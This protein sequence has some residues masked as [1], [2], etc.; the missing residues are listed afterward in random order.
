[1]LSR[2][3]KITLFIYLFLFSIIIFTSSSTPDV[4]VEKPDY[5]PLSVVLK[6]MDLTFEYQPAAGILKI[7]RNGEKV[8]L[9]LETNEI[10]FGDKIEFLDKK[11]RFEQG[12]V[13]V[14]SEGI[15]IMIRHLMKRRLRWTYKEGIFQIQ[16]W[17]KEKKERSSIESRERLAT[18]KR[19]DFNI[20][21]IVIDAGHGGK[22]PGGIGYQG[23]KEKDLVLKV[24]EEVT[25]ELKKKFRDKEIIMIRDSD[26]F[27][28]LEERAELANNTSPGQN[29]IF[30]S[31]HANVGLDK[32][33]MGYES[34]YLSF[35]PFGEE[36]R[37]VASKENSVLEF[38]VPE[39][40]EYLK[41]ILNRI[42]DIEYRRESMR[43]ASYIQE[44]L[45][46]FLG[47]LSVNRGVKSA[48]FYVLKAV[49]MPA[50][51]IEIGFLTNQK[52]SLQ[53]QDPEYQKKL[54]RGIAEGVSDFIIEFQKTE[55]FTR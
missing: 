18:Q 26:V 53:M 2:I 40:R 22:D 34:Y 35:S 13:M 15:D 49:K 6:Y 16:G 19:I 30:I 4:R 54:A 50:V 51:L 43:L 25:K 7:L 52:E 9:I 31:I 46:N 17:E 11:I 10:Y 32:N 24:A 48:F 27:L 20:H 21:R 14:P 44:R 28:S 1:M 8:T 39:T 36:A 45:N 33:T 42:V 41:D 23:I 12:K 29:A 3:I 38:E 5:I 55:G 37:E 47:N